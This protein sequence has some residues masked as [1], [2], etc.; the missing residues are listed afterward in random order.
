MHPA[1][2]SAQHGHHDGHSHSLA[3]REL[4]KHVMVNLEVAQ[5]GYSI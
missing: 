5:K 4:V 1:G 2:F 3:L